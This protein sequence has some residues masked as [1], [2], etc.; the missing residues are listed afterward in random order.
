MQKKKPIHSP[1]QSRRRQLLLPWLNWEVLRTNP[2]V[3]F[4]LLQHGSVYPPQDWA[5]FDYSQL[6]LSWACGWL[7]FDDSAWCVMM[8]GPRYGDCVDWKAGAAHYVDI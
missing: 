1:S 7:D 2:A 6:T 4:A 3:L 8:Y 5:A